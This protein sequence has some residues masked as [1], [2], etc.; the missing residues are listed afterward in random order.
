MTNIQKDVALFVAAVSHE[1][2]TEPVR[3][4]AAAGCCPLPHSKGVE[5]GSNKKELY[6]VDFIKP[7]FGF[8]DE[9]QPTPE[10]NIQVFTMIGA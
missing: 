8:F 5:R 1:Q 3:S 7:F 2:R 10:C 4:Q 9:I 6:G